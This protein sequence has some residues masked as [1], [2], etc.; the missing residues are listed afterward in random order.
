MNAAVQNGQNSD[1]SQESLEPDC[2]EIPEFDFK[3]LQL[4]NYQSVLLRNVPMGNNMI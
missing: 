2:L 1:H 3:Y 4:N